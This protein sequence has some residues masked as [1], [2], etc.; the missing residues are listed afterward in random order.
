MVVEE[1][2]LL[3]QGIRLIL[4]SDPL[5]R[6]VAEADSATNALNVVEREQPSVVIIGNA[7][8]NQLSALKGRA[9]DAHVLLLNQCPDQPF[10]ATMLRAGA[11]G[12]LLKSCGPADLLRGVLTLGEERL[13]APVIDRHIEVLV[14]HKREP[15]AL[16]SRREREIL[17]LIA[18]GYT[19]KGIARKLQLS[20]RTIGNHRARIMAKLRVDNCIQATAQALQL[21]LITVSSGASLLAG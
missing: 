13:G 20:P 2:A 9:P 16:L 19:S 18:E 14:H 5:I 12:Y 4:E 15:D 11:D 6:V 3:R 10:V 17:A 8:P 7:S 1:L 21:G